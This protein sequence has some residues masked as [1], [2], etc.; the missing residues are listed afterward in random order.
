MVLPS[1]LWREK[2]IFL[3]FVFASCVS[4]TEKKNEEKKKRA[5]VKA[6]PKARKQQHGKNKTTTTTKLQLGRDIRKENVTQA[7]VIVP[8]C[9]IFYRAQLVWF[10]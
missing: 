10:S 1:I 4:P 7:L 6:C 8:P 3:A 9:W 5:S 2:A